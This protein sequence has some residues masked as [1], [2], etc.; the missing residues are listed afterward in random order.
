MG[1]KQAVVSGLDRACQLV[2]EVAYRP[3][4]VRLTMPLPRWWRCELAQLS[5][6]LDVRWGLGVWE[7]A[8]GLTVAPHGLC[9]VCGRRPANIQIGGSWEDLGVEDR[10][11]YMKTHPLRVCYW[12]RL[13][14]GPIEDDDQLAAAIADARA[15][16]ISWRW[17]WEPGPD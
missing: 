10:S 5:M 8:D 12:C 6:W 17:R 13:P 14:A 3:A 7:S 16:S 9:D 11:S 4:V 1:L 2:D 15:R